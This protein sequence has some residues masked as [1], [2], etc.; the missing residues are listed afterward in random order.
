[1]GAVVLTVSPQDVDSHARWAEHEGFRFAMLADTEG[2]VIDAY[3]LKAPGVGVRRSVFLI[4]TAGIVRY[5]LT[6]GVRA[7]FKKPGAL[8][9]ALEEMS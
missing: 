8:A 7:I 5:R 4:D 3:G 2:T 6:A 9:R 1:V